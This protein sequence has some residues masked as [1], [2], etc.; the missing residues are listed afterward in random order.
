[1]PATIKMQIGNSYNVPKVINPNVNPNVINPNT[2]SISALKGGMIS[3]IHTI[4]PGC[5]GCGRH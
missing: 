1:M 5:G 2:N 4:K 3:R